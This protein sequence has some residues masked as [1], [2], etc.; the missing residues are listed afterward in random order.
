MTA[1]IAI[2]NKTAI[3]L[4]ADSAVTIG[5]GSNA[6]IY[7]TISK[8]FELSETC[9]VG[10]MIFNRLDFMGL[11]LEVVIKEYRRKR[12]G[13]SFKTVRDWKDD[14]F[15]YL[16]NEIPCSDRDRSRNEIVVIQDAIGRLNMLFDAHLSSYIAQ[17]DKF[18]KSKLNGLLQKAASQEIKRLQAVD[19]AP[20]FTTKKLPAR[21]ES[22]VDNIA[23]Q[24][25]GLVQLNQTSLTRIREFVG[26][27]L[28]KSELSGMFTGFVF[29]GFGDDDLCPSLSHV[30][31]DGIIT[32]KLKLMER[33]YV[34]IGRTGPE[35][36]ILG[37]AQDDMMQSFVNG[38]DPQFKAYVQQ[39]IR[40]VIEESSNLVLSTVLNDPDKVK[41]IIGA[42]GSVF[43]RM[44]EGHGEKMDRFIDKRFT[45]EIKGMVRSM[46]RQDLATL[47]E[48]LVDITS[49]KR[50]VTRDRETV[51]G[52]VDVAVI[53][54]SEG[55]VWVKRKHYFPAELNAR[56]FKRHFER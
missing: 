7:N 26:Y 53:S 14:F 38:V 31:I 16:V 15:H 47:A 2:L 48:S 4:A 19:F 22:V 54:R 41:A 8:I 6:K 20:G 52:D 33:N 40:E 21:L 5:G 12:R 1:E 30:E 28:S 45:Q 25:I 42:A 34:D 24:K 11:P 10:I 56:F 37:F 36:D 51:G 9:P 3:A 18:L 35:A 39:L 55:L 50:K 23:E 44:S 29:A 49:L 32:G 13:K 27:V 43:D 17:G 46:P